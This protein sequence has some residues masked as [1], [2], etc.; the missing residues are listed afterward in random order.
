MSS[1]LET[2][3]RPPCMCPWS[4]FSS[5]VL[6][7]DHQSSLPSTVLMSAF[8]R[9]STVELGLRNFL[10]A[11]KLFLNAICSLSLWSKWQIGH[12]KWFINTNKFLIKPFL[13]AKLWLHHRSLDTRIYK[14]NIQLNWMKVRHLWLDSRL[15]I[16]H[17]INVHPLT[18]LLK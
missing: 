3:D 18:Y 16:P 11:L 10:V 4:N 7:Q 9:Y 8:P 5:R 6:S 1:K 14:T 12:E 2:D 15:D 13:I 17:G